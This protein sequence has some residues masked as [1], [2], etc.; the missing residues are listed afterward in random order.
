MEDRAVDDRVQALYRI[1]PKRF[2]RERNEL[3]KELKADGDP[4][5]AEEVKR[6][7]KPTKAAWALDVVAHERP[8]QVAELRALGEQVREAQE[9][10]VAGEG[11][12]SLRDVSDRRRELIAALTDAALKHA[13]ASQRDQIE[14]TLEAASVDAEVGDR[15]TGGR[16]ATAHDRPSGVG[17]LAA[18]LASDQSDRPRRDRVRIRQLER[19]LRRADEVLERRAAELDR[20]KERLRKAQEAAEEA[21]RRVDDAASRRDQLRANLEDST[22]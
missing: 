3:A 14:A 1:D 15:L 9:R 7:R 10:A 22:G 20:A 8:E 12:R 21:Q 19:D 2:V 16:L 4:A 13:G 11:D 5:A 6:L 18:L 17:G